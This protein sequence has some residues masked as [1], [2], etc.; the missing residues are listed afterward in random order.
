MGTCN[1]RGGIWRKLR[2]T[3]ADRSCYVAGGVIAERRHGI[4]IV[5]PCPPV[6]F[7]RVT[8][9]QIVDAV[10]DREK[11]QRVVAILGKHP[12][13]AGNLVYHAPSLSQYLMHSCK[14]KIDV[15]DL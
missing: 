9:H 1:H 7:A 15:M 10:A 14:S 5:C 2:T 8:R 13:Q 3:V 11:F 6:A 12:I 4:P